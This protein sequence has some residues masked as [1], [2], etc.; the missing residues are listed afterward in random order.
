MGLATDLE[1]VDDAAVRIVSRAATASWGHT[2]GAWFSAGAGGFA[3]QPGVRRP[4]ERSGSLLRVVESGPPLDRRLMVETV[5]DTRR[6]E[7]RWIR[8]ARWRD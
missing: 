2:D 4:R 7:W 1:L 6:F 3:T 5:E 8:T